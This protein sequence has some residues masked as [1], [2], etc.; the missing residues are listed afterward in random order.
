L[1][2][3]IPVVGPAQRV[4]SRSVRAGTATSQRTG[5]RARGND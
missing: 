4:S 3:D 1:V 5:T 2:A